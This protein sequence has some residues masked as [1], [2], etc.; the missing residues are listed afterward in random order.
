MFYLHIHVERFYAPRMEFL[1]IYWFSFVL[2][3]YGKTPQ[4]WI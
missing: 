4:P 1:G 3:V 2:S